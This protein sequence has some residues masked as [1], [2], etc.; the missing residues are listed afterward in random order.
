ML[1][2]LDGCDDGLF[3]RAAEIVIAGQRGSVSLVQRTLEIGFS[4]AGRLM[5]A[6]EEAGIVGPQIGARARRVNITLD[7]W[8]VGRAPTAPAL[9]QPPDADPLLQAA[10]LLVLVEGRG[11]VEGLRALLGVSRERAASLM[12]ALEAAGVVE[13]RPG[14]G[15]WRL[16]MSLREWRRKRG[17]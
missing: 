9:A 3:D 17:A 10:T 14:S 4:R 11:S 8:R 13:R 2:A 15:E 1:F 7:D 6:L 5:D 12:R 16:R